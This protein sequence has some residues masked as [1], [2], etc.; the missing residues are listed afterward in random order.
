L[1]QLLPYLLKSL[2]SRESL[3]TRSLIMNPSPDDL[4]KIEVPEPGAPSTIV[5]GGGDLPEVK[6]GPYGNPALAEKDAA[7]L[8]AFLVAL[9]AS[10]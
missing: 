3:V 10:N 9:L 1:H 8:R 5:M 6:L 2:A 4:V 7:D